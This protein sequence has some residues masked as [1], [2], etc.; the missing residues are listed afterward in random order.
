MFAYQ[1]MTLRIPLLLLINVYH[2]Y[3][4]LILIYLVVVVI[5][6]V[7]VVNRICIVFILYSVS[8]IACV[9]LCSM[10]CLSVVC[11]FV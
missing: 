10:F 7:V 1:N 2:T 9:V 5:V 4:L 8:F 6:F 3:F 11:Y